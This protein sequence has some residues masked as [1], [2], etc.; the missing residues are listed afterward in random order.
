MELYQGEKINFDFNPAFWIFSNTLASA[1]T[2][3]CSY[4]RRKTASHSIWRN[5]WL[6]VE[7]NP[8]FA[9]PRSVIS[10]EN[11]RSFRNQ[12]DTTLNSIA[13]FTLARSR[14]FCSFLVFTLNSYRF[15]DKISSPLIGW[16]YN[17]GF[18]FKTLNQNALWV[19]LFLSFYANDRENGF[20]EL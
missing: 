6:S 15:F 5:F 17:F 19:I 8:R 9:S 3:E 18:G 20:N 14:D 2:A 7:N 11:S 16:C 12:S 4:Q 1:M 13:T 10:P